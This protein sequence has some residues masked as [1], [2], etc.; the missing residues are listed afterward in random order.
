MVDRDSIFEATLAER[1][2]RIFVSSPSDVAAERARVKPVADRLNGQ[3][4]GVVRLEVLRWEDAFYTAAH[5]FQEAIDQAIGNM[6]Q[7]DMVLCI[8]WKRAGLKLNPAIWR[9]KDGSAYE[10]GTVLEYET[11]VEVSRE[12]A[13][14]PDVFLFRKSA[15]VVYD[16]DRVAEQLEQYQLLQAVWK[17][18]TESEEG[19]NTAGYQSFADPDDLER[20]LEACLRQWLERRGAVAR[21]PVWD[22][23]L[24]GSPFR[25]LLS[26]EEGHSSVFFGREGAIA[27]AIAKLRHA[28][29]LLVIGASGSGKSSLLKAGLVPR[30]AS[31]ASSP[32]STSGAP[33]GSPPAAIRFLPSL[34]PCLPKARSARSSKPAISA[35]RICSQT[36]S[37]PAGAPP[38]LRCV[39]HSRVLRRR[40]RTRCITTRPGRR[41]S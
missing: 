32:T 34:M 31:P 40:A 27:R 1:T 11:A 23:K 13:G 3:L 6:S 8:V 39:P 26:F 33:P 37:P 24:K 28:P 4:E 2:L 9:R 19:Y 10:S 22:R 35:I 17:R 20:K 14:V 16:A 25:G 12:R 29:F 5:S 41:G 21:G 30:I 7:T 15:P 18:W 36:C 38:S